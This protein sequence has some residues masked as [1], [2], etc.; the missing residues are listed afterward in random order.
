VIYITEIVK[1]KK[2]GIEFGA[3]HNSINTNKTN[4]YLSSKI[5]ED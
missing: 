5:T 2:I 4:K 1:N 3:G